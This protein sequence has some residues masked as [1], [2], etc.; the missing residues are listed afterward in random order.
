MAARH[1]PTVLRR[2]LGARLR[3]LRQQTGLTCEQVATQ[4]RSRDTGTNWSETKVSRVETGRISV[5]PGDI[6]ELLKF[7]EIDVSQRDA[8]MTVARL[9]RQ[10]G[11]WH[12]YGDALPDWLTILVDLE[13]AASVIRTYQAEV[14]PD[15]LQT[16][17]YAQAVLATNPASPTDDQIARQVELRLA[18]QELLTAENPPRYWAVLSEAVLRRRVGGREIIRDQ[19]DHLLKV[20]ARSNVT[21]RVLPFEAGAHAALDGGSF[22][23][24]E[25]TEPTDPK[26]VYVDHLTGATYL[27]KDAE[28]RRYMLA[29]EQLNAV[30]LSAEQ[31]VAQ[32][33]AV[34][35]EHDIRPQG[36]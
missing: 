14:I 17:S 30:A 7:Y 22:V 26:V 24:L 4:L 15:L 31:S 28:T 16:E 9:A 36:S 25:F 5:H 8:I 19:L 11:W 3:L 13:P 29:F 34:H 33:A 1:S 27:D 18:R 2:R 32:I 23:V 6:D 35:R 21:I 20:C 12:V 10:R